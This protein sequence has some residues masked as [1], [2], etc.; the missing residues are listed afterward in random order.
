[1]RNN[2]QKSEIERMLRRCPDILTP[3]QVANW[4]PFG[5]NRV[6]E[7]LR[8]GA[9]RSFSYCGKYIVAK[10]DLIDYLV[11]HCEDDSGRTFRIRKDGQEDE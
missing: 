4:S 6:Y 8:S 1:M 2:D 9:L 5:V 10:D 7:L 3:R 11:E